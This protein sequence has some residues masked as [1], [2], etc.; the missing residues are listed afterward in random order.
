M[1]L[2]SFIVPVFNSET[3]LGSCLDSI[4]N[5]T[6]S[7]IEIICIDDC[8]TDNSK[9]VLGEYRDRDSRV[10]LIHFS[11]NRGPGAARN[12]GIEEAIGKYLRMVD[13]D[14]F[15]PLDSTEKMVKAAEKYESD[16]VRGGFLKCWSGNEERSKKGGRF[17]EKLLVNVDIKIDREL[18]YFDQHTTYLFRS[19]LVKTQA[20]SR[21]DEE[22]TNGEDV[23]FLIQLVPFMRRVSLIPE[24]VYCYRQSPLSIMRNTKKNEQY[25]LNLFRLYDMEYTFLIPLGLR[26]QVDHFITYH[27]SVILPKRVFPSLLKNL[28]LDE[29]VIVLTFLKEIID[30]YKL[31]ELLFSRSYSW[32]KF[33]TLP[34][35]TKQ[36]VILLDAGYVQEAV[37]VLEE[38]K[39]NER[40]LR[41]LQ[42]E[43]S[44]LRN[45][46]SWRITAPVR[47]LLQVIK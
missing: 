25:Y 4:L 10:K 18:W 19:D 17:P 22:M 33:F 24:V 41:K 1:V 21:Y 15:L 20:K 35:L 34:L 29:T 8:S 27:F 47:F 16:F 11:E 38:K 45:S 42:K 5:Q 26:E 6:I 3:Y 2:V 9:A 30:E 14:D 40:K 36:V 43:I 28:K 23:A 37:Q 46:R 39:R 32:Q 13:S 44:D 7:D 31:R 12:A